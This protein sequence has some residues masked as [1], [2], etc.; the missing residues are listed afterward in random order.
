MAEGWWRELGGGAWEV[1]S[2]GFRPAGSGPPIAAS[3]MRESGV[4]ISARASER[5]QVKFVGRAF[6]LV[7]GVCD[8]ALESRPALP[9]A[10]NVKHRPFDHPAAAK[11]TPADQTAAFRHVDNQNREFISA[12]L[13]RR[14][15]L[16]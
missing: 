13:C 8:H 6:D 12:F 10:R 4:D 2:P 14:G 15:R 5:A 1:Y 7:V 16:P 3:A 11:E 9:G